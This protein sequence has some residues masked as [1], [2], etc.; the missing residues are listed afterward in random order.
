MATSFTSNG[1]W[2]RDSDR[3]D[4]FSALSGFLAILWCIVSSVYFGFWICSQVLSQDREDI[5]FVS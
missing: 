2:S 3:V 5:N 4:S 1:D